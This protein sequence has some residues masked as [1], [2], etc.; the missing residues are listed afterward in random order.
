MSLCSFACVVR[1]L[2]HM[3]MR[4]LGVVRRRFMMTRGIV[5]SCFLVMLRRL[6][7]MLGSFNMMGAGGM[8]A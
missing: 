7:V 1:R 2:Q 5:S 8:G 4:A 3:S 6:L